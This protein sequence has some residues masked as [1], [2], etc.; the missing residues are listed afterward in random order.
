MTEQGEWG[1]KH[2]FEFLNAWVPGLSV[3]ARCNN[4]GKFLMNSG[5]A[6]NITFYIT[7]YQTRKQRRNHNIS[8]IIA[9]GF[10]Y[11]SEH[12]TYLESLRDQQRLLF[13][14]VVHTINH[15]QELAALMVRL[16]LM[17]WWGDTYWSH[18]YTAIY[19]ASFV[20]ELRKVFPELYQ[21][22]QPSAAEPQHK[23]VVDEGKQ[24]RLEMCESSTRRTTNLVI[25]FREPDFDLDLSTQSGM[26]KETQDKFQLLF[27]RSH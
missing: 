13:F 23:D 9:K 4:D 20:T 2:L 27:P 8:P 26:R 18:H 24:E 12:S 11:H 25:V 19:W 14:Q 21:W 6:M 7:S 22:Q 5:E 16:Y 1:V 15:E 17:G 10:A 3:N